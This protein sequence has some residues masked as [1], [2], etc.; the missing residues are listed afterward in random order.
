MP[1]I[2][3][4]LLFHTLHI[5]D[6]L[7]LFPKLD[8]YLNPAFSCLKRFFFKFRTNPVETNM[9]LS[10]RT[11]PR[12]WRLTSRQWNGRSQRENRSVGQGHFIKAI[13]REVTKRK[14]VSR[15]RSFIRAIER[16][17]TT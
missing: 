2:N 10:L 8:M 1:K 15:S 6:I 16:E 4:L 14:Q 9:F 7:C 5:H 12:G 11:E 3:L 13:E 17:V